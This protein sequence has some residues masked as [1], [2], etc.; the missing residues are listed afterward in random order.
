MLALCVFSVAAR[1]AATSHKVGGRQL[2]VIIAPVEVHTPPSTVLVKGGDL[3][4]AELYQL[5]FENPNKAGGNITDFKVDEEQQHIL[6][7]FEDP[8]GN[9]LT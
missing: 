2:D 4:K 3:K 6:I 7:T 9:L 5:Y 8:E 1:V